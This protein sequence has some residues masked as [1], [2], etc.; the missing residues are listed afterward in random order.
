MQESKDIAVAVLKLQQKLGLEN[1]RVPVLVGKTSVGKTWWVSNVLAKE[2]NMPV[3]KLLLQT[4]MPDEVCGFQKHIKGNHLEHMLPSWFPTLPS[5]T[6][7]DELDKPRDELHSTVLTFNR[8]GEIHGNKLPQGSVIIGA[9]NES[10]WLSDPFKARC[11]FLPFLPDKRDSII[12]E[13]RDFLYESFNSMPAIPE[14]VANIESGMFL[15]RMLEFF[16]S[17]VYSPNHQE[18]LLKG[19]FPSRVIP[20]I[21]QFLQSQGQPLDYRALLDDASRLER[22]LKTIRNPVEVSKHFW[23]FYAVGKSAV[24]AQNVLSM[25]EKFANETLEPFEKVCENIFDYAESHVAEV[26]YLKST[27]EFLSAF[28]AGIKKIYDVLDAKIQKNKSKIEGGEI[29]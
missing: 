8:N 2:L 13:L 23:G 21:K 26:S 24:D 19:L 3:V 29:V 4:Q 15:D 18:I 14:Q 5:I 7:L 25:I 1:S 28:S 12:L 10:E 20:R 9:M 11:I 17:L 22:F 6:F 16:P 27:D